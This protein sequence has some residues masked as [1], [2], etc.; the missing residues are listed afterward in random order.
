MV[1]C[2]LALGSCLR[3]SWMQVRG[4]T[5]KDYKDRE[6]RREA[7]ERNQKARTEANREAYKETSAFYQRQPICQKKLIHHYRN[8]SAGC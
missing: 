3:D 8:A 2:N 4:A 1:L 6:A 7:D 5:G